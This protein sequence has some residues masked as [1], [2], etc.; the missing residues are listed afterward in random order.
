[1]DIT[2]L[3]FND[4]YHVDQDRASTFAT[5][6]KAHRTP[7]SA[8]FFSGDVLGPSVPSSITKGSHMI[9]VLNQLGVDAACIGNHEFDFGINVLH[10]RVLESK[11]PWIL[12][13][14]VTKN[15]GD[16][17]AETVI[18]YTMKIPNQRVPGTFCTVG[19]LGIVEPDWIDAVKC[20]QPETINIEAPHICAIRLATE[21]RRSQGCDLIVA[22]THQKQQ[23]DDI[24]AQQLAGTGAVDIILAG[25]D[26]F[27]RITPGDHKS[28]RPPIIKSGTDFESF[29][30][31]RCTQG[32]LESSWN[33]GSWSFDF[34]TVHVH[35]IDNGA[36]N[37]DGNEKH[38][39][40]PD[41]AMHQLCTAAVT[42]IEQHLDK[43]VGSSAVNLD[44]RK[45]TIRKK[46]TTLGNWLLDLLRLQM[47]ADCAMLNAGAIRGNKIYNA[48]DLT[49][50]TLIEIFPGEDIIVSIRV[51][52]SDLLFALENSVSEYH[53]SKP[54]GV[55]CQVSGIRFCFDPTRPAGERVDVSSVLVSGAPINLEQMYTLA[56]TDFLAT[57]KQGYTSLAGH[58][59][60]SDAE[61]GCLVSTTLRN[62][63]AQSDA[64]MWLTDA[65]KQGLLS[66]IVDKWK[67]KAHIKEYR[68]T[69]SRSAITPTTAAAAAAATTTDCDD[70]TQDNLSRHHVFSK[71]ER[72]K[73]LGKRSLQNLLLHSEPPGPII[74]PQLDGRIRVVILQAEHK[75]QQTTKN[76]KSLRRTC[77]LRQR[78]QGSEVAEDFRE[79][80]SWEE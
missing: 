48:G 26:H 78:T 75:H 20:I 28:G 55:F 12:S 72:L 24:L 25:H 17:I 29:T 8:V 6:L 61:N 58:K 38:K 15:T 56:T 1:M 40:A 71:Q 52:G 69:A 46:E 65:R 36:S 23:A 14:V 10:Q 49:L 44:A 41:Y 11:F 62:Y 3:H 4:V 47:D 9:P 77:M 35:G 68:R 37:G 59:Y 34:N 63:F 60:L 22:L 32:S 76:N 43:I 33:N 21:L 73:L 30:Q 31:I 27:Y 18:T 70:E 42:D 79:S 67:T 53:H 66:G 39:Y 74:F 54:S 64:L 5:A 57:G 45:H 80:L 51:S 2:L 7:H 50:R 19:V 16:S 13:N